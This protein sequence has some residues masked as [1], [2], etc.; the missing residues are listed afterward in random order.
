MTV[1]GILLLQ[2]CPLHGAVFLSCLACLGLPILSSCALQTA[3]FSGA[4]LANIVNEAALLAVRGGGDNV[5]A[6]HM[7]SAL[8]RAKSYRALYS[9]EYKPMLQID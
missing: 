3:G 6:Q 8:S 7:R 2:L 5:G 9:V 1:C 4:E